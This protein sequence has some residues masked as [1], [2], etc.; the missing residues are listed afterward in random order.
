[1]EV[2]N[3]SGDSSGARRCRIRSHCGVT[4]NPMLTLLTRMFSGPSWIASA[5]LK[6]RQAARLTVVAK[7]VGSGWRA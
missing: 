2:K 3:A 4:T 7:K 1:M 5:L 6:L